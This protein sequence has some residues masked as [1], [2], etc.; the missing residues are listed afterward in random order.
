MHLRWG[1]GIELS[2]QLGEIAHHHLPT[3]AT[4]GT[5]VSKQ[6]GRIKGLEGLRDFA[7]G[8][9]AMMTLE[10]PANLALVIAIVWISPI[11]LAVLIVTGVL[12][13]SLIYFTKMMAE[14]H[15]VM[16][17]SLIGNRSEFLTETLAKMRAIRAA[18]ATQKWLKRFRTHS[19]KAIMANFQSRRV[20]E[21]VS[22]VVAVIG[23]STGLIALAASAVVAMEGKVTSGDMVAAMM[24]CW[25]LVGP[26]QQLFSSASA[27]ARMRQNM[28][29]VENLMKMPGEKDGGSTVAPNLRSD[30]EG[31][32]SFN[33]V[34][35]RYAID[36]DPALLG[37]NF[38]INPGAVVVVAGGNG[39]G[40]STLL[41]LVERIYL[42]QAGAISLD[43]VDIRQMAGADLRSRI[44]YMPQACDIFYGTV[45]QNLRVANPAA[46]DE[47][48]KWAVNMAGLMD[49]IMAMQRGFD[50]R[51]STNMAK[52]MPLGFLQRLSLART[53][54]KDAPVVLLD[55]PGTGL[56]E[57]GELALMRCVE[58]WRGRSTVVMASHRPSHMRAADMVIY[59]ERGSIMASGTFDEIKSIVMAGPR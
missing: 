5:S 4:E 27:L 55:E 47:E 53:I 29:Q 46:T 58:F 50:T 20:H 38:T 13:G 42:P 22:G 7:Q 15:L 24:I 6:V 2:L 40:K 1:Q 37:V 19:G 23:T 52:Q 59:M 54:L 9:L 51:I 36:A 41:K 16:T 43:N 31:L 44:T 11:V 17:T 33:R 35:F 49:D 8:P 10:L 30:K 34:S 21:R 25:R 48:M 45:A 39:S 18:G 12:Y 3:A 26:L 57:A 28:Q 32:L 56:N 14:R